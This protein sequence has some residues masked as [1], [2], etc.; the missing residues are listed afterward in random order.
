MGCPPGT[1]QDIPI[2]IRH[3]SLG[4]R[5]FVWLLATV[6]AATLVAGCSLGSDE[7]EATTEAGPRIVQPGA[8][9]EPPRELSPEEAAEIELP[10][11]TDADVRFM[12]SMI[13]HH[14]Q[15]L[16]M[17]AFVNDR[18]RR[19]D[20]PL[21]ARRLEISQQDE[22]ALMERWLEARAEEVTGHAQAHGGELLPGMLT[23]RELAGL[24]GASGK[25]FDRRFLELMIRHHEGAL[26]MVAELFASKGGGME[27]EISQ[28]ARHVEAD[29]HIEIGRMQEL[30][31]K[32]RT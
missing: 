30:L 11:Y 9:G 17:T 22:I 24:E 25:E 2:A 6:V 27:P 16:E 29:Q 4:Q 10:V 28:F 7:E 20:I 1:G 15:A 19:K 3:S 12:Q 13:H 31:Q 5:R 18:S 32:L 21:L 8:P 26:V 23:D 14:A